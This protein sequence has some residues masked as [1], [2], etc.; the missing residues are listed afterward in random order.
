ML[1]DRDI[2]QL[3]DTLARYIRIRDRA[4]H[5]TFRTPDGEFETAAFKGLFHLAKR[6]MRSR[7]LAAELG[8]DPSTVSRHVSQLVDLGLIRREADPHDGRATLLVVTDA[9]R[10]R[11]ESMRAGR[12]SA[13][14]SAM[15]EW[16]ADEMA[17]LVTLL[18]RFVDA[19]ETLVPPACERRPSE[20]APASESPRI[21]PAP[22]TTRNS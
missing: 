10:D 22:T 20:T 5:T 11:V 21:P 13:V 2:D 15:S 3:F 18:T 4:V 19:A 7:E 8:A 1:G 14:N 17:T 9:G 6:P 12:R 16:S